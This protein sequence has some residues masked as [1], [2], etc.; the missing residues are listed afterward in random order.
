LGV[1]LT[2]SYVLIPTYEPPAIVAG[3]GR[4]TRD[5]IKNFLRFDRIVGVE[6]ITRREQKDPRNTV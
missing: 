3:S 4:K 5:L 6:A 2:R 1:R